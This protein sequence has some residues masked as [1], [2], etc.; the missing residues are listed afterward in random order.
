LLA[1]KQGPS[2]FEPLAALCLDGDV[3]IHIDR[4]CGLDEV[5][6]ALATLVRAASLG[7]VVVA[8]SRA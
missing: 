2:D 7:K 5:P 8:I 6:R 3:K 4:T 1:V